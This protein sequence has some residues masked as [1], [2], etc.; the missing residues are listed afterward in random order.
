MHFPNKDCDELL[1]ITA[2]ALEP[3]TLELFRTSV[4]QSHLGLSI[5]HAINELRPTRCSMPETIHISY[6]RTIVSHSQGEIDPYTTN[7]KLIIFSEALE[8]DTFS[9]EEQRSPL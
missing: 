8:T 4:Q 6:Q 3:K 2:E 9:N 7:P 5:E 1:K